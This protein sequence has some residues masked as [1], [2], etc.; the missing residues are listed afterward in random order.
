MMRAVLN[1]PDRSYVVNA[2]TRLIVALSS[3]SG[4][5]VF[6]PARRPVS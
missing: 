3:L 6:V 5:T 1:E 2:H 4:E